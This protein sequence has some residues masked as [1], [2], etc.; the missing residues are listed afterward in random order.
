M[1]VALEDFIY[2]LRLN[3]YASGHGLLESEGVW[4][5]YIPPWTSV[6]CFIH[7]ERMTSDT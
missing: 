6:S 2:K 3:S 1:Q 5:S 7:K 4:M